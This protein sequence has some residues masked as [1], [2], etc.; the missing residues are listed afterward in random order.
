[1][2]ELDALLNTL[3]S[4]L[5]H[6]GGDPTPQLIFH[7]QDLVALL[8]N[9]AGFGCQDIGK[10]I[11]PISILCSPDQD[12]RVRSLGYEAISAVCMHSLPSNSDSPTVLERR[13]LWDA[14]CSAGEEWELEISASRIQALRALLGLGKSGEDTSLTPQV[15]NAEGLEQ[16][17]PETRKWLSHVVEILFSSSEAS[18]DSRDSHSY[19]LAS[20]DEME[21]FITELDRII[22][23]IIFDNPKVLSDNEFEE[24][25]EL[26]CSWIQ[27]I[28]KD[29][30][31]VA[32]TQ[33]SFAT[34]TT[35]TQPKAP[36]IHHRNTS[37]ATTPTTFTFPSSIVT[38]AETTASLS[39]LPHTSSTSAHDPGIRSF[40]L[41]I[42][43]LFTGLLERSLQQHLLIPTEILSQAIKCLC[44]LLALVMKPVAQGAIG[45]A[46]LVTKEVVATSSSSIRSIQSSSSLVSPANPKSRSP[47]TRATPR[48]ASHDVLASVIEAGFGA[49]IEERL[50]SIFDALVQNKWYSASALDIVQALVLPAKDDQPD[51]SFIAHGA[52]RFLRCSILKA[53]KLE[54]ARLRFNEA[55]ANS[56]GMSGAPSSF[57]DRE[58]FEL[59][60]KAN[61]GG[62]LSA[63]FETFG[64]GLREAVVAWRQKA[65][66]S[67]TVNNSA[68]TILIE[69]CGIVSDVL[70]VC[71]DG[72]VI[73]VPRFTGEIIEELSEYVQAYRLLDGTIYRLRLSTISTAPTPLL[74]SI[75]ELLRLPLGETV[76]KPSIGSILLKLSG[77]LNDNDGLS[78]INHLVA[79]SELSPSHPDWAANFHTLI[80]SFCGNLRGHP[81][82]RRAIALQ[83]AKVY[84]EI[85]DIEQ[86]EL[87]AEI[88]GDMVAMW[89]QT[90]CEETNED[91]L[92]AA[93]DIM[94][95][96]IVLATMAD[97]SADQPADK[98]VEWI[99]IAHRIRDLWFKLAVT[100]PPYYESDRLTLLQSPI[101]ISTGFHTPSI[102]STPAVDQALQS[103]STTTLVAST[104]SDTPPA[105]SMAE[106]TVN[107]IQET[108]SP[109][110]GQA[111]L[112][113][114][115]LIKAFNK[116]SFRSPQSLKVLLTDASRRQ[117]AS[118]AGM[119][120]S[121]FRN[122][123]Q[124]I[125]TDRRDPAGVDA[126]GR[127]APAERLQCPKARLV[128]LQW[129]LRLRAD[130]DHRVYAV[131]EIEAE[132]LP[133]ARLVYRAQR[134][135]AADG[136]NQSERTGR[137]LPSALAERR[138]N[139]A[140]TRGASDMRA[141][142]L[143][144]DR[145]RET[146]SRDHT[147]EPRSRGAEVLSA[148][149]SRSRSRPPASPGV[150]RSLV[151][152][153]Q[154]MIWYLPDPLA[155]ELER[156]AMRPSP[157][158]TTFTSTRG[159]EGSFWLHVDYYVET[160]ITL[161]E[162]EGDWEII[163]YILCHLPLQLSN[164]HFFCGPK[165]K[166][167][168]RK[169]VLVI[170]NAINDD[171]L[172][173]NLDSS[174]PY[175]LKAVDVQALL[176][177][178]LTVLISYHKIFD[179]DAGGYDQAYLPVKSNIVE[180]IFRGLAR[181][182]VTN[183][184]CLE[185]LSLAV[186]EL[187]DQVAKFTAPIVEKL[188]RIMSNPNMAVH[189]LE[190]LMII[191]YTPKL[192]SGSFRE[193]EYKRVFGVAL[194]YIEHH[195]RPDAKTLRTSDGRDSFALAQHVLN[196]AFFVIYIWFMAI[197]LEDRARYVPFITNKLISANSRNEQLE[198][199]TEICFDWLARYAYSNADP[200]S[201]SSFLYRSIV[202]PSAGAFN[203]NKSWDEQHENEM[204]NVSAIKAWKLGNSIVT[205]STMKHPPGWVRI[206][207]RRPSGLTELICRLENWPHVSPG[208]FAPDL[209]SMPVTM[210]SERPVHEE[211]DESLDV[212]ENYL[213]ALIND[214]VEQS[215]V[216][217]DIQKP[218]PIS[219]YVWSGVAPSQRRKEV[220]LDPAYIALLLSA[221]P[222]GMMTRPSRFPDYNALKDTLRV[223][224][225]TPVIDT[226]KVG[227]LYV[228]PDQTKESE[229]LRN[230]HGSPAYTR[231]LAELGR[232]IKPSNQLEVYTGG[233][234]SETHGDYAYAWW[235]D[236][237]QVIYHV[238]TV[239]PNIHNCL[240]KKQ[241]IGND[242]VKIIWNDG[243]TPFKFDTIPS[244]YTLINVIVEPHSIGARGAYSDNKHENEFFKIT[245][246]TAPTLPRI[247]PIGEFKIISAEKLSMA[248]R[249]FTLQACLFCRTWEMTGQDGDHVIPLQTNWQ[250]RLKFIQNSESKLP[251]PR[252]EPADQDQHASTL[253]H[254]AASRDFTL[255]Y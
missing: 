117:S 141:R 56:H 26:Y 152:R 17:L 189:I 62:I 222:V 244:E 127:P 129:L 200:K 174:L 13:Q 144:R 245:L 58:L 224:D 190:L 93:F 219:G 151:Q 198:P 216:I 187:P 74:H 2:S 6:Q 116:L 84:A 48:A 28:S 220:T 185:A 169:L 22:N 191:G 254:R 240:Y 44:F 176:Y 115:F 57:G 15:S 166:I 8:D 46:P 83:L 121:L 203:V 12:P 201:A 25:L 186:Y 5:T 20:E 249:H 86:E 53:L 122:I 68:E 167:Q 250:T 159:E 50:T 118:A 139:R 87:R 131:G 196:T 136:Q 236:M 27:R 82:S 140:E 147:R 211:G 125:G 241:E 49:S 233:L 208:D 113:V 54:V 36:R 154:E 146:A 32:I 213:T 165:T 204:L 104:S 43:R 111:V 30:A 135:K 199:T 243:G 255:A 45:D 230:R 119:A 124:L 7:A 232:V 94:S 137:D 172:H 207:S 217:Q 181:D 156:H 183:K 1:M 99:S 212:D 148:S 90:L 170:C 242:G 214:I 193:E 18:R 192:Y 102:V 229:I 251:P 51:G 96:E 81:K 59:G 23:C 66:S 226:H 184:P 60:W 31:W 42:G 11:G 197:K 206:V 202:A 133:L 72:S 40:H 106:P 179:P 88:V 38:P 134:P 39:R 65:L 101:P 100:S 10:V 89:E 19:H 73:E 235:D 238:A 97:E 123:V 85:T 153:P 188:S 227:V 182:G 75:T 3:T 37:A 67:A 194:L 138:R 149:A 21:T 205:I 92:T 218:D 221:Y 173:S 252:P 112:A 69:C 110:K 160:L 180:V 253:V 105:V 35:L 225:F 175:D 77:H 47:R 41:A 210:L 195:Y 155:V 55:V 64:T 164:K 95:A 29:E 52:T 150:T 247:T 130:R 70:A 114:I 120:I 246:Q 109:R 79:K 128:I 142:T 76:T 80:A 215:D 158:M 145:E 237:S 171:K 61:S 168:I 143:E 91:I 71:P 9:G 33:S 234:R 98:R 14:L 239:M 209:T 223:I 108:S 16:L 231:F 248:L 178:T 132:V 78:V 228:A 177:H 161:L 126:N 63:R 163:S 107:G 24:T 157:A 162:Y 34:P 103:P 4:E